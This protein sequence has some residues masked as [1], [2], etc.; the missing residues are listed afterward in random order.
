MLYALVTRQDK[1]RQLSESAQKE[2]G[3]HQTCQRHQARQQSLQRG[4]IQAGPQS[5]LRKFK[6]RQSPHEDADRPRTPNATLH[7]AFRPLQQTLLSA[8]RTEVNRQ[9]AAYPDVRYIVQSKAFA[10]G[11]ARMKCSVADIALCANLW[12]FHVILLGT[13]LPCNTST[14]AQKIKTVCNTGTLAVQLGP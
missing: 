4:R 2:N 3:V 12:Y 8:V 14:D 9:R 1:T 11:P 5:R 7:I 10:C 6:V 13:I